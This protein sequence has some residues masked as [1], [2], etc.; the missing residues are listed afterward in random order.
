MN[1]HNNMPDIVN[2][3]K[4]FAFVLWKVWFMIEWPHDRGLC[5]GR[6]SRQEFMIQ[7]IVHLMSQRQ[8]GRGWLP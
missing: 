3:Q 4:L 2:L 8:G 1:L 6:M 5:Q 7:Q